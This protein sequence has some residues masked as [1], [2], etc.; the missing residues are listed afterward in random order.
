[1]VEACPSE[2][3]LLELL[4]GY[5]ARARAAE[6]ETHIAGCDE[7]RELVAQMVR[8]AEQEQ[9]VLDTA[10]V[11]AIAGHS[12]RSA[13][14]R[15]EAHV[16]ASARIAGTGPAP[17]EGEWV[18]ND[19]YVVK[20]VLGAGGMGCVYEAAHRRLERRFAIKVLA[21]AVALDPTYIAR[22]RSEAEITS[23]L[24]HPNIVEVVDFDYHEEGF[25][26]L[27]MELLEGEPL[28]SR[29]SRT[30][31]P[32]PLAD[33]ERVLSQVAGALD[34]AHS[35]GVVHRDLTPQNVFLCERDGRD[36]FV[37]V[38][39]FGVSKLAEAPALTQTRTV[40][41]TPHFMS[42]E[43][44]DG[45]GGEADRRSDIFSMGTMLYQM[46]TRRVPFSGRSVPSVLYAIVHH[47]P[48]PPSR[49]RPD[50]PLAI[51]RV[52]LRALSKEPAR[53]PSSMGELARAFS[54]AVHAKDG[55]ADALAEDEALADYVRG[56][57]VPT[58]LVAAAPSDQALA[59]RA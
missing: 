24:E 23:R 34:A 41:G 26:Y 56:E 19:T 10:V 17:R 21:G 47:D 52:V 40:L 39:D 54:A 57:P 2:D 36:D 59:T 50:L 15:E 22:F 35:A 18:F 43:Q 45:R 4:D 8:I 38:L 11:T 28:G 6:L 33:I 1:M 42:P 20:R 55:G 5:C 46:L 7:C 14:L 12:P 37:K 16:P 30:Q 49:W 27:V 44:A 9:Q 13:T 48:D 51:E 32:L 53:R 31:G 58:D 3:E 29:I 25:P